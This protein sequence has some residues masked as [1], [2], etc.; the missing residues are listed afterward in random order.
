MWPLRESTQF[1]VSL[2]SGVNY[3]VHVLLLCV[4]GGAELSHGALNPG[5]LG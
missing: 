2:V 1:S 3:G 5:S 4:V